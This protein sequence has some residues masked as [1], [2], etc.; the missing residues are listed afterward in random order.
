MA[1]K[2]IVWRFME[3]SSPYEYIFRDEAQFKEYL[4]TCQK[5]DEEEADELLAR[6]KEYGEFHGEFHGGDES[7]WTTDPPDT[8]DFTDC[9]VGDPWNPRN[10][11]G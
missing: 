5:V 11:R 7:Y 8:L 1:S 9:P 2:F 4:V 10:P 6:L 3:D